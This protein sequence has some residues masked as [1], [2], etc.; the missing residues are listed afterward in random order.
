MGNA[1]W[2][3]RNFSIV[4]CFDLG[5]EIADCGLCWLSDRGLKIVTTSNI[6]KLFNSINSIN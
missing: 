4:D 6:Y 2:G 3:M 1:E 5:F